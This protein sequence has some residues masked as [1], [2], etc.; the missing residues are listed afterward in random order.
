M[1]GAEMLVKRL[2][3]KEISALF[4]DIRD[5]IAPNDCGYLIAG[6]INFL[7]GMAGEW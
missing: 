6:Y 7:G 2:I 5:G 4:R 1:T 3:R